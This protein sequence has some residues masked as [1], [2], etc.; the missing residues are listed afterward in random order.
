MASHVVETDI[1]S[2]LID[3]GY[4]THMAKD[5]SLFNQIDKSIS[6]KNGVY[7]YMYCYYN[8]TRGWIIYMHQCIILEKL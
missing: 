1:N 3:S 8:C 4:T 7:M 2:W 6:I 5:I